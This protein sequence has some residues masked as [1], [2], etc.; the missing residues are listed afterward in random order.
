MQTDFGLPIRALR[1]PI[2]ME[3]DKLF[4]RNEFYHFR[5]CHS[6]SRNLKIHW[7]DVKI[8]FT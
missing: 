2:I 6:K 4:S 7:D 3:Y 5:K 1:S 8:I